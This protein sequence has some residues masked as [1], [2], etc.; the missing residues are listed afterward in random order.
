MEVTWGLREVTWG[1]REVTWT[2]QSSPASPK[3]LL[4]VL[5]RTRGGRDQVTVVTR[6]NHEN[7]YNACEPERSLGANSRSLG[8]HDR[9]FEGSGKLFEGS[10]I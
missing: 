4:G 7:A 3:T 1:L 10:R 6:S 2:L 8:A 5:E 9:L